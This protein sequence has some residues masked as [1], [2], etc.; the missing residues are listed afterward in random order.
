MVLRPLRALLESPEVGKIIVLTQDPADL[1]PVLP[2]DE[3]ISL[4]A[5][6]GT[7]ARRLPSG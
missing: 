5:S 4:R 7:I 6:S 1:R 2:D 3:R